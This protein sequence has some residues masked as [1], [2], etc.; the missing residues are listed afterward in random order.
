MRLWYE[1]GAWASK[2]GRNV[3]PEISP[4]SV[5]K[6]VVIRHAALGDMVLVRPFLVEARKFFPNAKI[7]LSIVSNYAYG[8]PYDLAD[9]IHVLQGSD[10]RTASLG[11][12]I[13]AAK[14]I[15]PVDILFDLADTTRSRYLTWITKAKLKIGFPYAW[16]LRNLLFDATVF[17]S[18]FIF[19]A[20]NMLDTLRLLGACPKVPLRFRWP[21]GSVSKPKFLSPQKIVYFPFASVPNKC[22]PKEHFTELITSLAICFPQYSHIILGGIGAQE[23]PAYFLT[24]ANKHSNI[25]LRSAMPLDL[26]MHFLSHASLVISND[27]GIRNLAIAIDTPTL[28]IFFSTVPYRYWPRW[29]YKHEV[30]FLDDGSIPSVGQV[31]SSVKRILNLKD[32]HCAGEE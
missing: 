20:E 28:G 16:Y 25:E 31:A 23:D 22:W 7:T 17:R 21:N 29:G 32:L 10:Q 27:T 19:E 14:K 11:A 4:E 26:T 5:R 3:I 8:V 30:V 2:R 13:S 6:I 15:G 12:Q 18:D 24:I 9:S 1:R